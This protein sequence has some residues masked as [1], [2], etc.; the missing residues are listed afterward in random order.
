MNDSNVILYRN[1]VDGTKISKKESKWIKDNNSEVININSKHNHNFVDSILEIKRSVQN[2]SIG[3]VDDSGYLYKNVTLLVSEMNEI[4]RNDIQNIHTHL[5]ILISIGVNIS[6]ADSDDVYSIQNADMVHSLVFRFIELWGEKQDSIKKSNSAAKVWNVKRELIESGQTPKLKSPAWFT[7]DEQNKKYVLND[8]SKSVKLCFDKYL[9]NKSMSATARLLN[10]MNINTLGSA[11]AW[12]QT[13]VRQILINNATYGLLDVR[14]FQHDNFYPP[15]VSKDTFYLVQAEIKKRSSHNSD[16]IKANLKTS[17]LLTKIA[18][19]GICGMN[20][21]LHGKKQVLDSG[22]IQDYRYLNCSSRKYSNEKC[23]L[24][25]FRYKFVEAI[26]I[27]VAGL[28]ESMPHDNESIARVAYLKARLK[29]LES[30]KQALETKIEQLA[31]LIS[32]LDIDIIKETLRAK[33]IDLETVKNTIYK[34]LAEIS[35]INKSGGVEGIYKKIGQ[36]SKDLSND[37][38][39]AEFIINLSNIFDKCEFNHDGSIFIKSI[40]N[41]IH[42]NKTK[43]DVVIRTKNKVLNINIS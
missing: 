15:V 27:V 28:L 38:N 16:P 12:G 23:K 39:R 32:D 37:D 10:D 29:S 4:D 22:E 40:N 9:D 5:Q 30:D 19:C 21:Y 1:F 26:I 7:Y 24:P 36:L 18:K 17:N 14:T 31:D 8:L 35:V 42:I 25:S 13:S 2:G 6:I 20:L 43:G 33:N 41:E 34:T 11:K 3:N